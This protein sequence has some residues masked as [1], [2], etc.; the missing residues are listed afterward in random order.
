M[1]SVKELHVFTEPT[2]TSL[3]RGAF[4]FTDA[5]SVFDWGRMPDSIPHKGAALC[6]MGAATF[7]AVEAAGVP[8]HYRGVMPTQTAD[9]RPL[10]ALEQP[11]RWMAIDVA[12]RPDLPV[13]DGAYDYD[14]YHAATDDQY[15]V[16]LEVVVRNEVPVGSSLRR[17]KTPG[18]V[19]VERTDWPDHPV[20]L[21]DPIVEYSTKFEATDRYLTA[22]EAAT[23]AGAVDLDAIGTV[24]RRVNEAVSGLAAAAGFTH[25]DGKLEVLA[26]GDS[27]RVAD[28]VGTFDEHRFAY[29]DTPV[30]KELLRQF[31]RDHDPEWVDAVKTAKAAGSV[32]W[33]EQCPTAPTPLP[34]P[35]RQ[36]VGRLYASGANTYL[37]RQLF[38]VPPLE[39]VI[40]SVRST[41]EPA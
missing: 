38:D 23:I 28:V 16:P 7:E 29:D 24:A 11:P 30:S 10:G 40:E 1:T 35:I 19:G 14:A 36:L 26:V 25:Q 8:T 2:T 5:Y 12:T 17:R 3:G 34:E 22:M 39:T 20:S 31:Y 32:D 21:P 13:A 27:V 33:R 4:Y 37:D 18:A 41:L 6:A 15:L 9:P